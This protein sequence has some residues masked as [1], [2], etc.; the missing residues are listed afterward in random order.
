MRLIDADILDYS[1]LAREFPLQGFTFEETIQSY[2]R[3]FDSQPTVH[4]PDEIERLKLY[5]ET[6]EKALSYSNQNPIDLGTPGII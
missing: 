5:I 4:I 6:R 2:K 1:F 3:C